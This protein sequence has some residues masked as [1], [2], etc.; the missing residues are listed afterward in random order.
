MGN[1]Q[2][3]KCF[4][5]SFPKS[6]FF[7]ICFPCVNYVPIMAFVPLIMASLC[8]TAVI[9]LM[10]VKSFQNKK[11]MSQYYDQSQQDQQSAQYYDQSQQQYSQQQYSQQDQQPAQY[12]D[13]QQYQQQY[14]QGGT[15][16][17]DIT[18]SMVFPLV[19]SVVQTVVWYFLMAGVL[20]MRRNYLI[21]MFK[22]E[23]KPVPEHLSKVTVNDI[24]RESSKAL[25]IMLISSLIGV[26]WYTIIRKLL[27]YLSNI[28]GIGMVISIITKITDIM[29]NIFT[30]NGTRLIFML[31]GFGWHSIVILIPIL[32]F[33]LVPILTFIPP[34]LL[35]T[36]GAFTSICGKL[37]LSDSTLKMDPSVIGNSGVFWKQIKFG[38][39]MP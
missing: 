10:I 20:T 23:N 8:V 31:L 9:S 38:F 35:I 19:A 24:F 32:G 21:N 6:I 5:D 25:P 11:L 1:S 16:S 7:P 12:Y 13:Q 28:P 22:L 30:T 33:L 15:T 39:M 18:S 29:E 14:Q 26:F 36:W 4:K 2:F 37:E 17:F 34:N 3:S 27:P